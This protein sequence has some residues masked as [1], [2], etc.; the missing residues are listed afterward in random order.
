MSSPAYDAWVADA[1]AVDI[2]DYARTRSYLELTPQKDSLVGACPHCGGEDRF[3]V[4]S[5]HTK[6]VFRCRGSRTRDTRTPPAT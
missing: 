3:V 2:G 6:K 4:T 5:N 1:R